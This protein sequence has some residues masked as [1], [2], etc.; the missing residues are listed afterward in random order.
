M[1]GEDMIRAR[2]R[3]LARINFGSPYVD[4]PKRLTVRE[5][6]TIFAR[7]YGLAEPARRIAQLIDE[8]VLEEFIDRPARRID[9]CR[10]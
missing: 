6:L 3:V 2:H 9:D 8:L 7:L 5:N 10:P 4:L 1:L